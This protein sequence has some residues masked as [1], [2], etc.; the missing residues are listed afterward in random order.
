M[1]N[2]LIHTRLMFVRCF[3]QSNEAMLYIISK[4]YKNIAE[5]LIVLDIVFLICYLIENI[6]SGK[7]VKI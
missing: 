5:N 7:E 4:S 2:M 6:N 1:F 3:S